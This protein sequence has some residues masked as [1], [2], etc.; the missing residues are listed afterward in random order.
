[1]LAA[2]VTVNFVTVAV[3]V[4]GGGVLPPPQPI[5]KLR[6]QI[7]PSPSA[8]R[9]FLRP[10]G[11]KI[12]NSAAKPVPALSVH[13]PLAPAVEGVAFAGG[14]ALASNIPSSRALEAVK[15]VDVAVTWQFKVPMT[16][17]APVTLIVNGEFGQVTP[18]GSVAAVAVITT[19]PVNPPLGV[20]V[21]VDA[22]IAPDVELSVSGVEVTATEPAAVTVT[23]AFAAPE[24]AEPA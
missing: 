17:E 13:Q 3:F 12:R 18:G 11:R 21:M 20:T 24:E 1:M 16:A 9:Y 19:L 23:V 2:L 22:A 7:S 4:G 8:A 5:V 14:M 10:P 15:V 6:M